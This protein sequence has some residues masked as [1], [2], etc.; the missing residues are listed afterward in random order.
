MEKT[1]T[2][3]LVGMDV[4]GTP[5]MLGTLLIVLER[6]GWIPI[7]SFPNRA[8]PESSTEGDLGEAALRRCGF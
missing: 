1:T 8:P 6:R 3:V 5:A 7:D 2:K 4:E